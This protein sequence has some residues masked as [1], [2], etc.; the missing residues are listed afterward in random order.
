MSS[1][2]LYEMA[3]LAI[4]VLA[5]VAILLGLMMWLRIRWLRRRLVVLL[6]AEQGWRDGERGLELSREAQLVRC[7]RV[8]AFGTSDERKLKLEE[9]KRLIRRLESD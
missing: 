7:A 6:G 4:T 9:L 5:A 3:G 8:I 1:A 2:E